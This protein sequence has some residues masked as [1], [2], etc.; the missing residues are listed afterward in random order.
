M[1]SEKWPKMIDFRT[2]P[3]I[4]PRTGRMEPKFGAYAV[5]DMNQEQGPSDALLVPSS[6]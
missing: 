3:R 5:G 1:K 4:A 2:K 6:P